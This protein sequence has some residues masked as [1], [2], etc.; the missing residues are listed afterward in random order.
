MLEEVATVVKAN[1]EHL[2]VET[3]SR[4]SCSHCSS[5]GCSTSTVAKLFGIKRNR[6]Q[7]DNTLGAKAGQ[8]VVIG[9]PDDLLV[10]A[11]LWAYMMPLLTMVIATIA[12]NLSGVSE[13]IQGLLALAGLATGFT[14]VYRFTHN[15]TTQQ[16]F[17]PR[18][19]RLAK[20]NQVKVEILNFMKKF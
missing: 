9:I 2:W 4:S 7:L 18:L 3:E 17:K 16:Q 8:Q 1:P 6:L 11:S 13:G 19:L 12:G 20:Q 15:K 14:L 5:S 10:R